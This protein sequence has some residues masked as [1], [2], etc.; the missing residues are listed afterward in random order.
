MISKVLA[1]TDLRALT[2]YLGSVKK[3]KYVNFM[4]ISKFVR[5]CK[6]VPNKILT[7]VIRN[8]YSL[9]SESIILYDS[10][11]QLAL[12]STCFQIQKWLPSFTHKLCIIKCNLSVKIPK[13][14]FTEITEQRNGENY[15]G[16]TI[17]CNATG[18][19]STSDTGI[20]RL[21]ENVS[22]SY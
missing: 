6:S 3:S 16:I 13:K 19:V 15:A 2:V 20:G 5:K 11:Y 17:V 10:N 21:N 22:I 1:T 9:Y 12:W 8:I 4:V 14:Y 7:I 18:N